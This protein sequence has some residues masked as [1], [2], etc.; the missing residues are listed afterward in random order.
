MVKKAQVTGL[1]AAKA[2]LPVAI[3]HL[4]VAFVPLTLSIYHP[5]I[6]SSNSNS[7]EQNGPVIMW[8]SVF[9]AAFAD[10]VVVGVRSEEADPQLSLT[11]PG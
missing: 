4:A 11:L 8:K 6:V 1:G 2:H 10:H 7:T 5:T 9:R 3:G